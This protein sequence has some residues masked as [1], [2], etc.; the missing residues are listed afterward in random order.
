MTLRL[1]WFVRGEHFHTWKAFTHL[2]WVIDR[3]CISHLTG[4]AIKLQTEH[5]LIWHIETL[6][7]SYCTQITDLCHTWLR[8]I[9]SLL[10][11]SKRHVCKVAKH[12]TV[13]TIAPVTVLLVI[14]EF[15]K[16]TC[17]CFFD[18]SHE[19]Q[20]H[21]FPSNHQHFKIIEPKLG[22]VG[23]RKKVYYLFCPKR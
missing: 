8:F 6:D 3:S 1:D 11:I 10:S 18:K 17:F 13:L 4:I 7:M 16:S 5:F 19:D 23:L 20:N 21:I 9:H 2:K 15:L 12:C 14:A 22:I